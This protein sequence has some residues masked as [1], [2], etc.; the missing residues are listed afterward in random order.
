MSTASDHLENAV[1]DT[2]FQKGTPWGALPS[3]PA[4]YVALAT[5]PIGDDDTGSTITEANYTGYARVLTAPADWNAAVAGV[6]DNA[7]DITFGK[8][9]AGDDTVTHACLVDAAANGNILWHAAISGGSLEVSVN[10]TPRIVA[11]ALT[12]TAT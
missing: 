1:L 3:P 10:I 5:A 11:G 6:V 12:I 4:V 8:C 7:N 2:I 9:T